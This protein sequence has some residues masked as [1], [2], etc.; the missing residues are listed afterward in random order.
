MD[1]YFRMLYSKRSTAYYLFENWP[2][3]IEINTE[4]NNIYSKY[5]TTL[6]EAIDRSSQNAFFESF[7]NR[8][9]NKKQEPSGTLTTAKTVPLGKSFKTDKRN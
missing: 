6:L 1:P 7:L 9:S 4:K 5:K 3:K 8:N 2:E